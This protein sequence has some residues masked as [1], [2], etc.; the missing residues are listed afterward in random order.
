MASTASVGATVGAR[1]EFAKPNVAAGASGLAHGRRAEPWLR[2]LVPVL[3]VAFILT[4]GAGVASR[5][6]H[7]RDVALGDALSD[8]RVAAMLVA[9]EVER[10]RVTGQATTVA[11]ETA[12]VA[13][14]AIE[15]RRVLLADG[16]GVVVATSPADTGVTG[17]SLERVVGLLSILPP[18]SALPAGERAR[19]ASGEEIVVA[20][21][22]LDSGGTVAIVQPLAPILSSWRANATVSILLFAITAF[23]VLLL[24]FAFQW[25]AV[26]AT[27]AEVTNEKVRRR[28]ETALNRG[29]CGLWDW[30]LARGNIYWSRSMFG[31][32][33]LSPRDGV[34][35]FGEI[36]SMLHPDDGDLFGLA[37]ELMDDRRSASAT[38]PAPG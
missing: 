10:A 30:D 19:L 21:A 7:D 18:T 38:P 22:R 26:R 14:E 17:R 3:V 16:A 15:G 5:L 33:G 2:R 36:E 12:V 27:E 1:A 29:R 4:L 9:S 13:L 32:L 37:R 11:L 25:Q 35:S 23:V 6:L 31:M 24:G 8:T 28:I 20:T 34:L